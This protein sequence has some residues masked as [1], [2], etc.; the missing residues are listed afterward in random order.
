MIRLIYLKVD[1]FKQLRNINLVFPP[2]CCVLIEGLN[3]AGK[4]SLFESIYTAYTV[5]AWLC[6]VAVVVRWIA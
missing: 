2:R 3:E 4:S 5:G 6:G 1:G